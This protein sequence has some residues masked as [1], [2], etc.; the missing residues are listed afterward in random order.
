[1]ENSIKILFTISFLSSVLVNFG[2]FEDLCMFSE[3]SSIVR[4]FVVF[5]ATAQL[6][7]EKLSKMTKIYQYHL[8]FCGP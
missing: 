4:A 6:N 1:M 7:F 3:E 5:K 2:F 8:L